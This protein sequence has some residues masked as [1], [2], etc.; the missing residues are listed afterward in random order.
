MPI[1]RSTSRT[2]SLVSPGWRASKA[3]LKEQ[4]GR[5]K[6]RAVFLAD[7]AKMMAQLETEMDTLVTQ[8][9]PQIRQTRLNTMNMATSG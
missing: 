3:A 2:F 5:I 6:I 7:A 1:R 8:H 9:A 4:T